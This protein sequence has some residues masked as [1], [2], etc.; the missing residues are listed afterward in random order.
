MLGKTAAIFLFPLSALITYYGETFI[1]YKYLPVPEHHS[2]MTYIVEEV[3]TT[4]DLISVLDEDEWPSCA[5][6]PP[7]LQYAWCT[8]KAAPNST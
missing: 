1:F 2:Y 8:R 5:I 4:T 7:S 6:R 3:N